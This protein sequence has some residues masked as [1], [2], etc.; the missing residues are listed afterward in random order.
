MAQRHVTVYLDDLTG[1]ELLPGNHEAV[2]FALDGVSYE[3]DVDVKTAEVL[4]SSL[5]VYVAHG[6]RLTSSGRTIRRTPAAVDPAAVRA[7]AASNGIRVSNRGRILASVVEQYRA[8][9]N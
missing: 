6:R 1:E 7:W 3:L 4:R 2:S 8:A 9:G 5:A